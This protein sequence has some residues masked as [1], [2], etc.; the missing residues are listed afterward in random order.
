MKEV[1]EFIVRI[2][3]VLSTPGGSL[4]LVGNSG[5]GR[6][7]LIQLWS[8]I[9]SLPLVSPKI[10][11]NYSLKNFKNDLKAVGSSCSDR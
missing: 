11:R 8:Y 5:V 10:T 2:D 7:P 9:K 1:L 3:R 6:K 4:L